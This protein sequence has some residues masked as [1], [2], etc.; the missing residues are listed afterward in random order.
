MREGMPG[1][2]VSVDLGGATE[3]MLE[4]GDAGDGIACD[5]ADWADAKVDAGRRRDRLAGRSA[6]HRGQSRAR[7]HT[8]PPFSFIYGG[9]PSAELLKT[10]KLKRSSKKLD[11]Q[12][13]QRTLTWTDPKT[14]L[15]VRCVG[16]RVPATS[17]PS[18][19]R[20]TSRTPAR[21]T[22]RSSRTSRR[23]TSRFERGAEGEFVLHHDTGSPCTPT[24]YQPLETRSARARRSASPPPAG[25]RRNSDLPYFNLEWP[26]EGVIVV[27][28][29][30]G[31]WAAE[32]TRDEANGLRCRGR[33]GT[34]ALQAA[35]RR[36]GPHAA[37][38]P[39]VLE[40]RPD[41]RAEHLAALDARPQPAPA[42]RQAPA[43]AHGRRAARTSS[44]R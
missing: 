24:D 7:T 21:P 27:V 18:S 12:R 29:W 2:P 1:V 22:R 11:E 14:G 23:S 43:A 32:F 40:G 38:R 35:P 25:G 10:W 28:G 34:D 9:K 26:G 30:P 44:A 36:G 33:A 15:V 13:T 39:A 8:E 3:F 19:G 6:D 17:R 4:V 37:G 20:S 41:P 16:G 31:Q 5:Q 42:R